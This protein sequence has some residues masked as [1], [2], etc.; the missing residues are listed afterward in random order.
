MVNRKV[1]IKDTEFPVPFVHFCERNSGFDC[2]STVSFTAEMEY[3]T[4]VALFTDPGEWSVVVQH[5]DEEAVVNDCTSYDVLCRIVDRRNG[6]IDVVV[7][8]ITDGEA[9]EELLEVLNG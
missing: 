4:V 7:G 6:M 3:A 1:R 8:K 5:E 9:L 2:R